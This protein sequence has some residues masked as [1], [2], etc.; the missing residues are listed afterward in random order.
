V[1][2]LA[3]LLLII[4][5]AGP[6][7][8][9]PSGQ[10]FVAIAFHDIDDNAS[11]LETDS[12]T[13][14]GLAQFF[15]WLKGTGWTA[16]SLDDLTAAH[17][18]TRP[19]PDKAILITFDDGYKSLYTRVFPL[20]KIYRYPIVSALVGSWMEG[21]SGT[22]L[23]GDR[24]VPR[25]TFI[26][27][28]EAR[29]MQASGLVEFASHS[30]ALHRGVQANP[31]GNIIPAAI[32]WRYDPATRHYETDAEYR[33]RIRADLQRSRA[34]MA[35]SLGRAPRAM[36]WPFGRYTGPGLEVTRQ[37]GF[38][39]AM[40]LEPEAAY[41]SDLYSIHRY[42]PSRNP[43]LGEIADN[44][45]F[46]PGRPTTRRIACLK[47]DALAAQPIGPQQDEVLG[48]LI[49]GVRA[50]GANTVVLD[51]NADLPTP[52]SALGDVFF[53]NSLRPLRADVLSRA[54][55]QIR[56]RGGADVFLRLPLDAA[57]RTV[58]EAGVA[59]LYADMIR[60]TV[61]DGVA[62]DVA[63]PIAATP[64][65]ADIPGDI[66]ARRAALNEGSLA[67][68]LRLAL[69]AYRAAAAIDPRQ[70]LMLGLGERTGPPDWADIGLLPATRD[71]SGAPELARRLRDQGWLRPDVSGRVALSLPAAPARQ[72]EALRQ[73]QRVGASAFAL[74]PDP[75]AL[76][77]AAA[78]SAAFSASR[79]PYK[80]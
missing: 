77:P 40:T 35:A 33:N 75:P 48:R 49:E 61:P 52:I 22:V 63:G 44:L 19:L 55:W 56:T 39:F 36:V 62:M 37:L 2:W 43:G 69:A 66:R 21:E 30:Y 46:A 25:S 59:Q 12:V 1:R 18:G 79:Y 32:T 74:C 28:A 38:S 4:L 68:G 23:Y 17:R 42:F 65:V 26:S 76:P 8:A 51:G 11:E 6:A 58:G 50:L 78:L 9:Q 70:R 73:A 41:T 67:G 27:W 60:Y 53:P 7:N 14:K 72:S 71:A 80:P 29:E 45:R 31:Q 20:L 64:I 3:L 10:R 24:R 54:T 13:T 34:Q 57:A 47:I 5:G 15:D 16:V